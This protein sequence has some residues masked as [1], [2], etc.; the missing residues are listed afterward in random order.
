MD[1]SNFKERLIHELDEVHGIVYSDFSG[2]NRVFLEEIE[3]ENNT[4]LLHLMY[5][6][7]Y[8][9]TE[10]K[11]GEAVAGWSKENKDLK[12]V[13]INVEISFQR[14]EMNYDD[15]VSVKI[16]GCYHGQR[17]V[18]ELE[19]SSDGVEYTNTS[20]GINGKTVSNAIETVAEIIRVKIA[21]CC[22]EM[23]E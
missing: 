10:A 12:G 22:E 7:K 2:N 9:Q 5:R 19:C 20:L 15:A 14:S 16:I 23:E 21:H 3:S 18:Y 1:L 8:F 13:P 11:I 4:I 6:R 17:S